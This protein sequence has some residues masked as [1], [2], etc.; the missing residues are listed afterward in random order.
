MFPTTP[1]GC[2]YPPIP[3]NTLPIPSQKQDQYPTNTLSKARPIPY[4]YPPSFLHPPSFHPLCLPSLLYSFLSSFLRFL[5][6]SVSTSF[7]CPALIYG[8]GATGACKRKTLAT[9]ET[10]L[11]AHMRQESRKKRAATAE[12]VI[13]LGSACSR[14]VPSRF[15][16]PGLR[17]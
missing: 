5:P 12:P 4:Q 8:R 6:T 1:A 16:T 17:Q 9:Y 2:Q 3:P 15:L 14:A 11:A 13:V 7:C 10:I